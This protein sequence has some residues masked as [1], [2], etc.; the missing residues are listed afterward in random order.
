[1]SARK[2]RVSMQTSSTDVHNP[3]SDDDQGDVYIIDPEDSPHK[4]KEG[5]R[6]HTISVYVEDERGM[7]NR[8]AGVFARRGFNI[9]SLAV[10]LWGP[11]QDKALFTIV[12]LGEDSVIKALVKQV[13]KLPNVRKVLILTDT[14]RVERGMS[15][16]KVKSPPGM[17]PEILE[18]VGIFHGSVVDVSEDSMIIAI[19]G[20]PGKGI[21]F[22]R[23][24]SKYGILQIARTGK[25]ALRRELRQE[26][27]RRKRAQDMS[28]QTID[29]D[30]T[31]ESDKLYTDMADT[32]AEKAAAAK[33]INQ[34]VLQEQQE[35]GVY[36]RSV[37]ESDWVGIWE[38]D[39]FDEVDDTSLSPG[40][41]PHTLSIVVDN[42]SGVLDRVTGVIAR[43]GYNVQSLA[44][45]PA[46][47]KG[48][49]RITMVI[50]G[51]DLSIES[52][53]KQLRKLVSVL[54]A[55]D[56]TGTP[57][58]QRELM[59]LKVLAKNSVRSEVMDI[60]KV[61]GGVIRDISLETLTLEVI[62]NT[63]KMTAILQMMEPYGIVEVART[64][65]VALQRDG[66]VDNKMLDKMEMDAFF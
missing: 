54:E 9:E 4:L 51:T 36:A 65:A 15:L 55:V 26:R 19:T 20:D 35:T 59:M 52:L 37:T 45:G 63:E 5:V 46:E 1:V 34:L 21:A 22:Q 64:G 62:G 56:I 11:Q 3:Y 33:S 28:L 29:L 50:P 14:A 39:N 42:M 60:A 27:I 57:F 40:L 24:M 30:D 25:I 49:S 41:S 10:G 58:V 43:R 12:V 44:V 13:Y 8:V 7:I 23:I 2:M 53:L 6:R 32:M 16:T 47:R 61:F 17:R 66:G 18:T 38:L 31:G 48:V